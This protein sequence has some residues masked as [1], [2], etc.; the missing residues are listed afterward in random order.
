MS[1]RNKYYFVA[2]VHLGAAVKD[3][4]E[5]ERKFLSFLD[6]IS[7]DAKELYLLGDIF[8][9]WYE[10]KYVIP[11]GYTRT[12]GRLAELVDEG[13]DVYFSPGNHDV[14]AYGYFEEELGIKI[15]D[16]PYE[17]DIAGK[18]FCIGH[19]DG[20]GKMDNGFKFVRWAFHNKFL[21]KLF[22]AIHPRWAFS[23][24]YSWAHHS[25]KVKNDADHHYEI[26]LEETPLVKYLKKSGGK[27]DYY[28]FGH[29]HHPEVTMLPEGGK[30]FMLGDWMHNCEYAVFDGT[31]CALVPYNCL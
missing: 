11:R 18:S 28:I 20:L 13:V 9:F 22:S 23:W 19:G 12:L 5:Y 25:Y 7:S 14:W 8:D 16:Q 26:K 17:L 21:Q 4:R 24:G 10:Y 30:L 6:D 3:K 31:S 15:L 27:Y 1:V 2:D 29:Y